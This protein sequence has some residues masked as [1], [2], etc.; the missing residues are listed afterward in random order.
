M[1]WLPLLAIALLHLLPQPQRV[2]ALAC[3]AGETAMP[4]SVSADV[5]AAAVE[6]VNER[7]RALGAGALVVR[8]G[9]VRFSMHYEHI[10]AQA[11]R[12][13]VRNGSVS[14]EAGDADG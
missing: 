1:H 4:I 6:L 12:M 3:G 8:R 13:K 2:E 5:D 7:W 10:G 14:I 11:Y 9:S